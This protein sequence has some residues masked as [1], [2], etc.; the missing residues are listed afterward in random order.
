MPT[1]PA[2]HAVNLYLDLLA[3]SLTG[4]LYEPEP[5]HD[6]PNVGKFV[7]AFTMHYMRGNAI[8]M[9]PRVR[10]DNIR[11]CIETVIVDDVPGD[12]IETGVWRGGRIHVQCARLPGRA[13]RG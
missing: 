11:H 12:V 8:T 9:L 6:N 1:K 7:T 4:T 3:R 10:L 13:G 5:D 2:Q